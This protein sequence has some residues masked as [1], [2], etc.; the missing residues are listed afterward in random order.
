MT[1]THALTAQ[2][3]LLVSTKEPVN[4]SLKDVMQ[5]AKSNSDKTNASNAN[6]AQL[7]ESF[8][9]TLVLFQDQFANASNS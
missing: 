1:D 2:L 3:V 5:T 6:H 4:H 7:E 8:K 9:V